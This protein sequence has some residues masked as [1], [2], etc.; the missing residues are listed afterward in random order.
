MGMPGRQ[1]DNGSEY[2][3]GFNGKENDNEVKGEGNQQDY[4]MRIYDPRLGRFLSIDP[5]TRDYP[6]YTPYQFAGNMPISAIDLDGA[7]PHNNPAS[8]ASQAAARVIVKTISVGSSVN[9]AIKNPNTLN[10]ISNGSLELL[11]STSKTGA[12]GYKTDTKVESADKFNMYVSNSK[13]F[14]VDESNAKNFND[15]ETFVVDEMLQ[16]MVTG[17]GPENY[18]FPTNGIISSKFMESDILKSAVKDHL[19]GKTVN[20]KQYSFD[21]ADLISDTWRNG[22]IYNITGFVGSG[23]IT[24]TTTKDAVFIEIF[25]ITSL[26]SGTLGKEAFGEKNYPKS[27]VR[28]EGSKTPFGNISQTFSLYIPK[29]FYPSNN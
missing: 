28:E 19:S 14:I 13:E 26:T 15:Y 27:S 18:V 11:G 16:N 12:D 7:E 24:I 3:Y 10:P 5:L 8:S 25:N 1:Y 21:G 29:I 17:N 4:G 6:W 23:T 22:N 9:N 20:N 2:R